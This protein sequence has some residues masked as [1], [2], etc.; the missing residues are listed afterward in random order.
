QLFA[1]GPS[2]DIEGGGK[3]QCEQFHNALLP[4][5]L[6]LW[7]EVVTHD[8]LDQTV[9]GKCFVR[10][11]TCDQGVGSQG[12]QCFLQEIAIGGQWGQER[13]QERIRLRE[14]HFADG[15]RGQEGAETEQFSGSR[16]AGFH[17]LEGEQP[18]RGYWLWV[19]PML[20]EQ[21]RAMLLVDLLIGG[22]VSAGCFQ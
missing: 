15:V 10:Y 11:V 8:V 20:L 21:L 5:L 7:G 9:N 4:L 6:G 3:G 18:S 22:E 19:T 12:F 1:D 14:Q 16:I 13:S 2:G 17:A